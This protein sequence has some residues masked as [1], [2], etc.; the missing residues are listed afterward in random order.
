MVAERKEQKPEKKERPSIRKVADARV[1]GAETPKGNQPAQPKPKE[2]K[3]EVAKGVGET[4]TVPAETGKDAKNT[5]KPEGEP[6]DPIDP[7][8]PKDAS[9][10]LSRQTLLNISKLPAGQRKVFYSHLSDSDRRKVLKEIKRIKDEAATSA[11]Q[12]SSAIE[13]YILDAGA[14]P[15]DKELLQTAAKSQD[16]PEAVVKAINHVLSLEEYPKGQKPEYFS[17]AQKWFEEQNV[18]APPFA[19]MQAMY[20]GVKRPAKPA[21]PKVADDKDLDAVVAAAE[22]AAAEEQPSTEGTDITTDPQQAAVEL[23]SEALNLLSTDGDTTA[24]EEFPEDI[25][26]G[27]ELQDSVKKFKQLFIRDEADNLEVSQEAYD[28]ILA[29]IEN[30][31]KEKGFSVADC[32]KSSNMGLMLPKVEDKVTLALPPMTKSEFHHISDKNRVKR[33]ARIAKKLYDCDA[34]LPVTEVLCGEDTLTLKQGP[35]TAT[36]LPVSEDIQSIKTKC[37]EKPEDIPSIMMSDCVKVRHFKDT[38]LQLGQFDLADSRFYKTRITDS[39]WISSTVTEAD[40]LPYFAQELESQ[41]P[42]GD[43]RIVISDQEIPDTGLEGK[44]TASEGKEFQ[45]G[46]QVYHLRFLQ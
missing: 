1:P 4:D 24:L 42:A 27:E 25:L 17:E 13:D 32:F 29:I 22:A 15:N 19:I 30:E 3:Q 41:R 21:T 18:P 2:E 34:I 7:A 26:E 8:A 9:L 28:Q 11:E 23:L 10:P 44:G 46:E 31:L 40:Q 14:N 16:Y 37:D 35:V 5:V 20:D 45:V 36:Y 6:G 43:F 38:A 12:L 39:Y 33:I